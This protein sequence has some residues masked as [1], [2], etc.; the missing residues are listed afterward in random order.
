MPV[1]LFYV[2]ASWRRVVLSTA[3]CVFHT[4]LALRLCQ[5]VEGAGYEGLVLGYETG[6]GHLMHFLVP[7]AVGE[8]PFDI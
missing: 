3:I 8:V 6:K 1:F 4:S 5:W 2:W 7:D